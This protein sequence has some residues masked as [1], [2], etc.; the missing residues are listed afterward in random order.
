MVPRSFEDLGSHFHWSE[1]NIRKNPEC[2]EKQKSLLQVIPKLL[3]FFKV[4]TDLHH[5]KITDFMY[6]LSHSLKKEA[7]FLILNINYVSNF[8]IIFWC[9]N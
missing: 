8:P 4:E 2:S 1:T 9:E 3:S 6:Y 5:F 7:S